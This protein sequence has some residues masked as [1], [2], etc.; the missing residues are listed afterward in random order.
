M[1]LFSG[2]EEAFDT[3][4]V[5]DAQLNVVFVVEAGAFINGVAFDEES[6]DGIEGFFVSG[7]PL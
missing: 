3:V 7:C 6:P 1:D 2:F 5:P 4:G